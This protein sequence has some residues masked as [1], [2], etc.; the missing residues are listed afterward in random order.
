M[1]VLKEDI[2][3]KTCRM[4]KMVLVLVT[5][6]LAAV[7]AVGANAEENPQKLEAYYTLA[8]NYI[9]REDYA[10]AMEYLK[11]CYNYCN[12][13]TNPVLTADLHLKEGCVYTMTG[14]YEN[15]LTEL[16]EAIRINPEL[17]EAYL[18]KTQVYSDQGNAQDAAACLETYIGLSGDQSMQETLA[19]L[20][21]QLGD[22][23]KASDAYNAY[24]DGQEMGDVEKAF[25]KGTYKMSVGLFGEAV[26]DFEACLADETY[27]TPAQYNIG[28]CYMRQEDYANALPAFEKCKEAEFVMDG[29][30]YNRAV[31]NMTLGRFAEAAEAF[32]LSYENE[33]YKT[34]A[35]YNRAVCYMT[36]GEYQKAVDDF[37]AYIAAQ[38]AA[39][40]EGVA[41]VD[42][43]TYYRGVCYMSL[44]EF[45]SAAKDF[46]TCVDAGIVE[47]DSLFNRALSLLQG[48][49]YEA[50]L[51]D[52]TTCI[53]KGISVNEAYFYRSY[54]Y[55]YLEKN[56]EALQDLTVCIDNGYNLANAYY[57]RAQVYSAMNDQ[58]H[59]LE[60]LEASL[61][62]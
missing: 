33:S 31:C 46:S 27:G 4:K 51:A 54:A 53:E 36:L 56:E 11:A 5:V 47:A 23:A 49:Q 45:D 62:Y 35:I 20:Y 59:Y 48:G 24:V 57:Q 10:K 7:F 60:D 32:T 19:Q 2:R 30:D 16:D 38:E 58:D 39:S 50:A 26:A 9:G 29:I 3:M 12:E 34:D 28:L 13:E 25:E 44:S 1:D 43:A 21:L 61:A 37:T 52:F 42:V 6:V 55:R 41:A 18:V 15:A 40:A 17:S 14:E 8:I 22:S